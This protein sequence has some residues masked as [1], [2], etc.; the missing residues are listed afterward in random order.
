MVT[1]EPGFFDTRAAALW[2]DENLYVAYWIEE[3]FVGGASRPS[4]TTSCSGRTM[5]KSSSTAATATTS[6]RSTPWV[7][8]YEIFFIWRDAYRRGS[9]FDVPEFDLLSHQ[10]LLLWR[11]L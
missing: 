9:R 1:G 11:R 7:P 4:A 8:I 5:W 3:P 2:D 10:A 6:S